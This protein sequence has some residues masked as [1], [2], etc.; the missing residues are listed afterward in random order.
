MNDQTDQNNTDSINTFRRDNEDLEFE[1]TLNDIEQEMINK[2][3]DESKT[4]EML[5]REIDVRDEINAIRDV[6]NI[7][8]T[9][10]GHMIRDQLASKLI[11]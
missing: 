7:Q 2:T 11:N 9:Q 10:D 3:N 6:L 5:Q 4:I 1:K 8:N